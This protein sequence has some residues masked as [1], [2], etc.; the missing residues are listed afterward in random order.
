LQLLGSDE[1]IL[2]I[3]GNTVPTAY[4][5]QSGNFIRADLPFYGDFNTR[6]LRLEP[7]RAFAMD[8]AHAT[9]EKASRVSGGVAN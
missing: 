1:W 7:T 4:F 5:F 9:W 3:S 2:D 8:A 6:G